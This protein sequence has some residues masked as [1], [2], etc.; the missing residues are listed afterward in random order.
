MPILR[1]WLPQVQS[2]QES[3]SSHLLIN[4]LSAG[5]GQV[6]Q[7]AWV[8]ITIIKHYESITNTKDSEEEEEEDSDNS[9][10]AQLTTLF[11]QMNALINA[12]LFIC[13]VGAIPRR[14]RVAEP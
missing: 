14:T 12:Y 8:F 6:D 10:S 9:R 3:S 2:N 1:L 11:Q 5:L 4:E 7:Q 13:K